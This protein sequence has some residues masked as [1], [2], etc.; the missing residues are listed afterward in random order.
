MQFSLAV[1]TRT[2]ILCG[3]DVCCSLLG[4]SAAQMGLKESMGKSDVPTPKPSISLW[5]RVFELLRLGACGLPMPSLLRP[6]QYG[7]N[8]VYTRQVWFSAIVGNIARFI[9]KSHRF[10]SSIQ[11]RLESYRWLMNLHWGLSLRA[12]QQ[13]TCPFWNLNLNLNLWGLQPMPVPSQCQPRICTLSTAHMMSLLLLL[14]AD[15][16]NG[17]TYA[18][19]LRPFVCLSPSSSVTLC[20]VAKRCVLEQKLLLTACRTS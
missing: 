17:R 12:M 10:S 5:L 20:I 9:K 8:L 13:T 15:R 11:W 6:A 14:L 4:C 1:H 2:F 18:T 3:L 7:E 19:M 16:T